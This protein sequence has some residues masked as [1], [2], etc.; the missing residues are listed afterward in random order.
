[1][2]WVITEVIVHYQKHYNDINVILSTNYVS[3][4]HLEVRIP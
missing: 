4:D 1:M 2:G 3:I